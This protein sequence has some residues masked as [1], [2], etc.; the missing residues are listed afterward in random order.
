MTDRAPTTGEAL[1]EFRRAN[2]LSGDETSLPS[3]TC[4]LGPL[5]I[6]LPNFKWRRQAILAHDLHHV[7]TGYPCNMRGEFQMAAWE[8][9]AGPMPHWAAAAFCLPLIVLGLFW[10]P[11]RILA[12][13]RAGRG[14]RTLHG[15]KALDALL[16]MPLPL[17]RSLVCSPRFCPNTRGVSQWRG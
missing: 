10:S 7:F 13:F 16:A 3:W 4:R 14:S 6:R 12:A 17:A 2:G 9:G 1:A 15:A 11:R 5:I 8:F